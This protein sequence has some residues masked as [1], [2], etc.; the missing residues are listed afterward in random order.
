MLSPPTLRPPIWSCQAEAPK[1]V[2]CPMDI[3]TIARSAC[4]DMLGRVQNGR[5]S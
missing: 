4:A 2:M 3:T 5:A 1:Q